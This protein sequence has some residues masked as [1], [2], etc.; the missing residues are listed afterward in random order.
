MHYHSVC[1]WQGA[2]G[3]WGRSKTTFTR[4][5]GWVGSSKMSTFIRQK[6]S[7]KQDRWSKKAKLLSTQFVNDSYRYVIKLIYMEIFLSA[8]AFRII[9]LQ[10]CFPRNIREIILLLLVAVGYKFFS[11]NSGFGIKKVC[12]LCTP[13]PLFLPKDR[14]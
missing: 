1:C 4:R 2:R 11:S 13:F 12:L 8:M 3:I 10:L 6:L 7:T 9:P 14:P 5:G